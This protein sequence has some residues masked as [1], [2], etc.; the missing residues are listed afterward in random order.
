MW[1]E[2]GA[3]GPHLPAPCPR[4]PLPGP[5]LCDVQLRVTAAESRQG[6]AGRGLGGG[7]GDLASSRIGVVVTWSCPV[8]PSLLLHC[9]V[10]VD[11]RFAGRSLDGVLF[12][13]VDVGPNRASLE[14]GAGGGA[15]VTPPPPRHRLV[16]VVPTTT[17]GTVL[18][19]GAVHQAL[20][21]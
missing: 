12:L 18:W 13:E 16:S 21:L 2:Q 14:P 11:G 1:L 8:V 7:S 6:E 15:V 20:S 9:D 17:Q 19:A 4:E 10:L 3:P 5:V